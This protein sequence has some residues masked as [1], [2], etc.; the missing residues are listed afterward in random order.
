MQKNIVG[1]KKLKV[2]IVEKR[3]DFK[4]RKEK[5]RGEKKESSTE[6]QKPNIDAEVYN[7]NKKCDWIC[8]YAYTPIRI[9]TV[10]QKLTAIYW[11][12]EQKKP[13]IVSSRSKLTTAQ[14]GEQIKQGA[15]W[16]I[17]Q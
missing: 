2:K 16:E 13:K 3:K 12:G 11:P 17:K 9:K 7:N 15:N 5:K 10:Q 6:L 4:K 14:T 1:L 8:T